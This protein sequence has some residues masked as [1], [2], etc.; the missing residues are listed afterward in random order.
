MENQLRFCC[1]RCKL[2]AWLLQAAAA[3]PGQQRI[4]KTW[5]LKGGDRSEPVEMWWTVGAVSGG[6]CGYWTSDHAPILHWAGHGTRLQGRRVSGFSPLQ[7][8]LWTERLVPSWRNCTQ[9]TVRIWKPRLPQDLGQ[10]SHSSVIHL[11]ASKWGDYQGY[12]LGLRFNPSDIKEKPK[13]LISLVLEVRHLADVVNVRQEKKHEIDEAGTTVA[14]QNHNTSVNK[15][16][17]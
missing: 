13:S 5:Y 3:S 1:D 8:L 4:D 2:K 9:R 16:S 10:C 7:Y 6:P 12:R 11:D 17:H 15:R 14:H